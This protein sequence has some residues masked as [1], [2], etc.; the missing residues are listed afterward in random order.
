MHH[1]T[2]R[3]NFA[4]SCATPDHTSNC[5]TCSG[6]SQHTR[7]R[8]TESTCEPSRIRFATRWPT[9]SPSSSWKPSPTSNVSIWTPPPRC[10]DSCCSHSCTQQHRT[11]GWRFI[12]WNEMEQR[13]LLA[14]AKRLWR[15]TMRSRGGSG[16]PTASQR[17]T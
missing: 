15:R 5:A 17:R 11:A 16:P 12:D 4:A 9:T 3:R 1:R 7:S 10:S 6:T 8:W 14:E 2:L 13:E